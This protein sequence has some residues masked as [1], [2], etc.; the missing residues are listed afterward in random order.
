MLLPLSV[1]NV[2]LLALLVVKSNDV[3]S[4]TYGAG[5]DEPPPP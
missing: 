3:G 2:R 4:R 1:V 5:V